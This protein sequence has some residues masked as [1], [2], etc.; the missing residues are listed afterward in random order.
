MRLPGRFVCDLSDLSPKTTY[1]YKARAV[2]DD[3]SYGEV[4]SFTT[5][6]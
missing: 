4:K 5:K 1:Y 3:T 6:K 2:G